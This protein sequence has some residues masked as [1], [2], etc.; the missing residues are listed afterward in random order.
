MK[1]NGLTEVSA[2]VTH[3]GHTSRGYASQLIAFTSVKIYE[4]N[5]LPFLH[6]GDV[7]LADIGLYEKL[8]FKTL[9][10]IS[11]RNFEAQA[12]SQ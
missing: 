2:V 7:N 1:I 5:K 9:R 11:F 6:V 8:G 4:E 3:P 12:E 10:N